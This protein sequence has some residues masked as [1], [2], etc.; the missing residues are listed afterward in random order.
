MPFQYP[1]SSSN[2]DSGD[3]IKLYFNRGTAKPPKREVLSRPARW[4]VTLSQRARSRPIETGW[5]RVRRGRA[6][7]FSDVVDPINEKYGIHSLQIEK[8]CVTRTA[9]GSKTE[10]R[11]YYVTPNLRQYIAASEGKFTH[12]RPS[13]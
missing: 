2:G 13:V 5:K 3:Q 1:S 12:N 8:N 6:G 9:A 11:V 7:E 10:T 4:Y